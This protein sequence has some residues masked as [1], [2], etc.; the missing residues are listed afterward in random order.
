MA[1]HARVENGGTC[2]YLRHAR[3]FKQQQQRAVRARPA[4]PAHA[5]L[6]RRRREDARLAVAHHVKLLR[7]EAPPRGL[8]RQEPR[9]VEHMLQRLLP[10]RTCRRAPSRA[11]VSRRR[12]VA[13]GAQLER[14]GGR[15][16]AGGGHPSG[17]RLTARPARL[18]GSARGA[19]PPMSRMQRR[20]P[21]AR[22]AAAAAAASHRRGARGARA[23]GLRPLARRGGAGRGGAVGR[24]RSAVPRR[25]GAR[26][27]S[28]LRE[29]LLGKRF[30]FRE[31]D[32]GLG[33]SPEGPVRRADGAAPPRRE[34]SGPR[35]WR[36][37]AAAAGGIG[38]GFT[39]M[40][41][42]WR[43]RRRRKKRRHR[44]L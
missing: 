38:R 33:R 6:S 13:A 29:Q 16:A 18:D 24:R 3:G 31:G 22:G 14:R 44:G 12:G 21:A 8:R 43:C 11:R 9:G 7:L 23:P 32:G 41:G 30:L 26:A 15:R 40:L 4:R 20:C 42:T 19:P 39:R 5:A 2:S 1:R 17:T 10:Q 34:S 28:P 35:A 36:S 25:C 27:E 37:R